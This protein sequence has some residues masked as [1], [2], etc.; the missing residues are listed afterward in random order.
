MRDLGQRLSL[1]CALVVASIVVGCGGGGEELHPGSGT[2]TVTAFAPTTVPGG[3]PTPFT[4]TGL[5]FETVTGTTAQIIFHAFGGATPFAHGAS[6]TAT[7]IGNVTSGTTITG[8]TPAATV[9]GTPSVAFEVTVVLESGVRSLP[10]AGGIGGLNFTAPTVTGTTPSSIP[11]INVP[12]S[13]SVDGTGFGPIGTTATVRFISSSG[14]MFG[15]GTLTETRA[16]GTIASAT[17]ITVAPPRATICGVISA[18]ASIQVTLDATGSCSVAA[19]AALTYVAPA[20]TAFATVGTG[21]GANIARQTL[22]NTFNVTGTGFGPVGQPVLVR[23]LAATPV[24]ATANGNLVSSI[25]VASLITGITGIQ[26]TTPTAVS[27]TPFTAT[28]Q[29]YFEDGTCS[30]AFGPITFNPPPVITSFVNTRPPFQQGATGGPLLTTRCLACLSTPVQVNGANFVAGAAVA[31]FDTATGPTLPV[32]AGVL[33]TPVVTA[34]QITGGSPIDLTLTAAVTQAT[35]RVTNPDGQ[36]GTLTPVQ[37]STRDVLANVNASNE[38]GNNAE[39]NIAVN[40]TNSRNAVAFSHSGTGGR[41]FSAFTTDAGA[42][43][44]TVLI[45]SAIDGFDV[46]NANRFVTDPNVAADAFGN[47]YIS[48]LEGQLSGGNAVTGTTWRLVL[49]QSANGGATWPNVRVLDSNVVPGSGATLDRN[50][51]GVGLAR[52]GAAADQAVYV[53]Y[54][55]FPNNQIR[56]NGFRS[57][58]LGNLAA[59]G[60]GVTAVNNLVAPGANNYHHPACAVG[61]HGELC[62]SFIERNG[63]TAATN[64]WVN[65]DSDGLGSGAA[66]FAGQVLAATSSAPNNRITGPGGYPKPQPNRGYATVPALEVVR[67][68]PFVG[69][70]VLAYDDRF[71]NDAFP[72]DE[73]SFG[74]RVLTRFSD[75]LGATW[76]SSVQAHVLDTRHQWQPWLSADPVSGNLYC[77]W[78]DSINDA[79]NNRAV[80]RF[81][82]VSSSGGGWVNPLLLSQVATDVQG[83]S[84]GNDYLEYEGVSAVGEC[85]YACWC[86]FTAGA[87]DIFT[88]VFQQKP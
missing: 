88:A 11:A 63:N 26:G 50:E 57:T 73:V 65:V 3:V 22:S 80:Q 72:G 52:G 5:N 66:A 74:L 38:A 85:V 17:S 33:S 75:S 53:A 35:V 40:P 67:A 14:P 1:S 83:V 30:N 6:D 29:L 37:F 31:I 20:V 23:F 10:F 87:G 18:T 61:P 77:T 12:A 7:V 45:T 44:T 78:F 2:I 71:V 86:S 46:G 4:L 32:G 24:F 19:A 25:D 70:I 79:A 28:A 60:F 62:I 54:H 48:Y 34:A 9:C 84:D 82:A 8:T 51:M 27:T 13:I 16:T 47:F 39:M 15:G 76:S 36:V 49:L 81:S 21:G 41:M 42:T 58:G 55:D 59:A 43:W 64:I 68:G 69:R 56:V